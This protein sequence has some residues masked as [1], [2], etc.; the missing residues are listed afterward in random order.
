MH[1]SLFKEMLATLACWLKVSVQM[2]SLHMI[3]GYIPHMTSDHAHSLDDW[4][5]EAAASSER[6]HTPVAVFEATADCA[7]QL[8]AQGLDA[9]GFVGDALMELEP[10]ELGSTELEA[11]AVSRTCQGGEAKLPT[12]QQNIQTIDAAVDW[13][14]LPAAPAVRRS[15]LTRPQLPCSVNKAYFHRGCRGHMLAG[16]TLSKCTNWPANSPCVLARHRTKPRSIDDLTSLRFANNAHLSTPALTAN[17]HIRVPS[18]TRSRAQ[19][20]VPS[21]Y[22]APGRAPVVPM[23]LDLKTPDGKPPGLL[24]LT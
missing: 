11:D 6:R 18:P 3:R 12:A 8:D 21:L 19:S 24:T 20:V 15:N 16:G 5:D 9:Q 4:H 2:A 17:L 14:S 7:D 23:A 13:S 10:K 1:T 22:L